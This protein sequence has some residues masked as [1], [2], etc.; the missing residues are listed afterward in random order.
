MADGKG[1][2]EEFERVRNG[3]SE[4]MKGEKLIFGKHQ[5]KEPPNSVAGK[6]EVDQTFRKDT[7]ERERRVSLVIQRQE[8]IQGQG[9]TFPLYVGPLASPTHP[10]VGKANFILSADGHPFVYKDR[11]PQHQPSAPGPSDLPAK[12]IADAILAASTEVWP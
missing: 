1:V 2:R 3:L 12:E 9:P 11:S 7:E 6:W 4:A 5:A 10:H 8:A